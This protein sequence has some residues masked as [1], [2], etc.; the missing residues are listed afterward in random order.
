MHSTARFHVQI[1]PILVH[2]LFLVSNHSLG[3]NGHFPG[4][5]GLAGTRMSPFRIPFEL[6]VMEGWWQLEPRDV[7]SS[8]HHQQTNTH[9]F[10]RP[11]A[12]PVALEGKINS[13]DH[14]KTTDHASRWV[15]QC[16]RRSRWAG[17]TSWERSAECESHRREAG[18]SALSVHHARPT[19]YTSRPRDRSPSVDPTAQ[20]T[21]TQTHFLYN[22]RT[23]DIYHYNLTGI[24]T[25]RERR[26]VLTA[27]FFKRQVLSSNSLLHSL[28]PDRWDNEITSSLRNAK[29]FYSFLACTNRFCKSFLPYRLD[30]YT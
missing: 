17:S 20:C 16:G 1:I 18:K 10:Y 27:K 9:F 11:D 2:N 23:A 25:L 24:D 26:E 12:L 3:F 29:P 22:Q 4:V 14:R 28:M 19:T 30:N 6:R 21:P 15:R 13:V 5:P 7:Q 8:S